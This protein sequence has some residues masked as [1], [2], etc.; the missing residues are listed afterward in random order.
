[1]DPTPATVTFEAERPRLRAIAY[2]MLGTP[3]DADD[4]VQEAWIRFSAAQ[5]TVIENPAAWLTTVVTRMSIDRLRSAR[6]RRETYVG[7]WLPGPIEGEPSLAEGPDDAAILAESLSLG[8]LA[9]LERVS[10]LE[11]AVFLLHDVFGYPL[12]EVAEIIDRTPAAVR[13][14]AKRARDH[15]ADG[16]PRFTA[17]PADIERLT[18]LMLA[19][20]MSGDVEALES[21]LAD[22]IVHLSDGGADRRAARVPI[23]GAN[24]VARLFIKLATRWEPTMEFHAVQANGQSA[25]Y[26]T[27]HGQPFMLVTTNWVD[28]KVTASYAILNPEKLAFFHRSWLNHQIS[29]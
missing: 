20:T 26:T 11:R 25:M 21:F 28:G 10:P 6:R 1:M 17:D 5:P 7:P 9:V 15:I 12:A 4:I 2:R 14:L 8:F 22:D 27:N 3:D 23:V 13:Q 24:R 18:Q 16:R 29:Q 19:A